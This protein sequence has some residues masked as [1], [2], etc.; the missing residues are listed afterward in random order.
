[1]LAARESTRRWRSLPT[2]SA[3]AHRAANHL[4]AREQVQDVRVV[5]AAQLDVLVVEDVEE[6]P[7]LVDAGGHV[8]AERAA[9][10]ASGGWLKHGTRVARP[11][12]RVIGPAVGNRFDNLAFR[13]RVRS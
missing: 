7:A 4:V 3:D 9:G 13:Y 12:C 6:R 10:A 8:R 11:G 1:M 2:C 5:V